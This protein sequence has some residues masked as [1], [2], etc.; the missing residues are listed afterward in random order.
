M[1]NVFAGWPDPLLMNSGQRVASQAQW[2]SRRAE[3]AQT[4]KSALYGELPAQPAQTRCTLLHVGRAV[5]PG[6]ANLHTYRIEVDGRQ[7]F[8]LRLTLAPTAARVPVILNG[9]GC[10]GYATQEVIETI[11]GRG[12]AFAQ[13]NRTEILSDVAE[14]GWRQSR[15]DALQGF[16]G[17]AIAAWAWGYQRAVDALA[18]L[19]EI[20]ASQIAIVGHSRGGK[21]ALLAGALDERIAITSANNSGAAGAGSF[22]RQTPGNETLGDLLDRF[23]FW[24]APEAG[25][26]RNAG[27]ALPFDQHFLKALMAPRALLSTE[28]LQDLWANPQGSWLTHVAAQPVFELCGAP[29]RNAI[30]FRDGEHAHRLADWCTLLDFA[31]AIFGQAALPMIVNHC[32]YPDLPTVWQA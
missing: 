30:A 19:P 29:Q 14:N 7:A 10:W 24:L 23:A 26:F 15:C 12:Y 3:I 25:R 16:A 13:F 11:V 18:Q 5:Q 2:Q 32:P 27:P 21:A 4:L 9:D 20:N 8:T 6:A 28:A 22:L 17:G 31:D 1:E